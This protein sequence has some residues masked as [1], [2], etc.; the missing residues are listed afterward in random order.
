VSGG[1]KFT[2]GPWTA[3]DGKST[4]CKC[5]SVSAKDTPIAT[6][7]SGDW[8]DEYPSLRFVGEDPFDMK[9]EAYMEQITYGNIAPEVACAN[10]SLIA[11][12]PDLYA[13]CLSLIKCYTDVAASGDCGVWDAEKDAVVVLGRAA[14]AKAEGS[15]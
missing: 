15:T 2:P 3:H 4:T 1:T 9:V 14:L 11:A 8:G 12:A 13:A 7:T 10:A 6:V 5:G